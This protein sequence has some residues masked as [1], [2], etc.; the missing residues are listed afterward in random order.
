MKILSRKMVAILLMLSMI[1][2]TSGISTFAESLDDMKN[3]DR[4]LAIGSSK[5]IQYQYMTIPEL[6]QSYFN[7]IEEFR[8][9]SN[10]KKG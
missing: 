5:T 7:I 2:S 1:F 10:F 8:I 9:L 3:S 4:I 6:I